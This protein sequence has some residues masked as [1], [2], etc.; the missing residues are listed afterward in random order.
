MTLLRPQCN[1]LGSLLGVDEYHF[2][3][4][5]GQPSVAGGRCGIRKEDE[6]FRTRGVA[7]PAD[8][9]CLLIEN[10]AAV[11]IESRRNRQQDH[12]KEQFDSAHAFYRDPN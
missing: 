3:V 1:F 10:Q 6:G 7:L 4:R 11:L 2:A 9:P 8:K 12:R 5:P